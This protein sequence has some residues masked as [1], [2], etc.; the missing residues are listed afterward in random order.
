MGKTVEAAEV[1]PVIDYND[2]EAK[3]KAQQDAILGMHR[4]G[5]S[6]TILTGGQG[7]KEDASVAKPLLGNKSGKLY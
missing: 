5:R 7:L 1:E 3:L 4:R 2:S 6:S